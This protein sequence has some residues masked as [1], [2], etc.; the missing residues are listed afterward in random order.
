ML[1]AAG[2][3]YQMDGNGS[4]LYVS[5][6]CSCEGGKKP[7]GP[8]AAATAAVAVVAVAAAAVVTESYRS[9]R[10]GCTNP[11]ARSPGRLNLYGSA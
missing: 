5:S 1:K 6:I 7:S 9:Y 3:D 4:G 11:C 10:Q 8:V 2:Y